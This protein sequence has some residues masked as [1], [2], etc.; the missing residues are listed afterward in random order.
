MDGSVH[1][2]SM[3]KE[4]GKK[5]VK[6]KGKERKKDIRYSAV[7]LKHGE[8]NKEELGKIGNIL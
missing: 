3:P 6:K 4:K 7:E 5:R 2:Y 1:L 8:R